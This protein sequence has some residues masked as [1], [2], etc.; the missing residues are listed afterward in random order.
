MLKLTILCLISFQSFASLSQ[1]ELIT[2]AKVNNEFNLLKNEATLKY[3][4]VVYPDLSP[5]KILSHDFNQRILHLKGLFPSINETLPANTPISASNLNNLFSSIKTKI[6]SYT[7]T[8]C[9]QILTE[10]PNLQGIDGTYTI[11]INSTNH[12]VFCDMTLEGGGW[13]RINSNLAGTDRLS[14]NASQQITGNNVP[15]FC[16][17][18][19]YTFKVKNIIVPHAQVRMDLTRLGTIMQ[20][21]K[22][23]MYDTTSDNYLYNQESGYYSTGNLTSYGTCGWDDGKWAKGSGNFSISGLLPNWRFIATANNTSFSVLSQCGYTPDNGAFTAYIF[24]R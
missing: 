7:N 6:Q 2:S 12:Q 18:K 9:N 19:S 14:F 17:E 10:N 16:G 11:T 13:T 24:V 1:G 15:N 20:C 23:H 22:L 21:T 5:S 3:K 8:S 4:N